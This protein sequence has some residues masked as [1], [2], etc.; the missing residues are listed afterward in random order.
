MK[1]IINI[2]VII[3]LSYSAH[4]L[5]NRRVLIS[6]LIKDQCTSKVLSGTKFPQV[7][8]TD[9][10]VRVTVA[11]HQTLLVDSVSIFSSFKVC[12]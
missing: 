9:G 2:E 3:S 7:T 8:A 4:R 1:N 5:N 10:T 6:F 11:S 12:S